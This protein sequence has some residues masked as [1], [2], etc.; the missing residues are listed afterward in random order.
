MTPII[1]SDAVL[2]EATRTPDAAQLTLPRRTTRPPAWTPSGR[3]RAISRVRDPNA[4]A[5]TSSSVLTLTS[6]S[7]VPGDAKMVLE[8]VIRA[9]RKCP[10]RGYS[11]AMDQRVAEVQDTIG[12]KEN[13]ETRVT[14]NRDQAFAF[15]LELIGVERDRKAIEKVGKSPAARQ[16]NTHQPIGLARTPRRGGRA[17]RRADSLANHPA[18]RT[19]GFPG[20]SVVPDKR[21]NLA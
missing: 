6:T 12:R 17:D 19:A 7:H 2:G 9:V 14:T 16:A 11:K 21:R 10:D 3:P 5:T 4:I 20:L 18:S 13:D 8:A 1:A 15:A